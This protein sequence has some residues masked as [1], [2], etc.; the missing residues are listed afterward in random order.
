MKHEIRL[1]LVY[2]LPTSSMILVFPVIPP[3]DSPK[4]NL[5]CDVNL[6]FVFLILGD[7]GQQMTTFLGLAHCV[8]VYIIL[9][10]NR[11]ILTILSF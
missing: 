4:E 5:T 6:S 1:L 8:E 9:M 7:V 11:K 10:A 3:A 2:T